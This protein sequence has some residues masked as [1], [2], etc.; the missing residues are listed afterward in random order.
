MPTYTLSQINI[1]ED[2]IP[3]YSAKSIKYA[4]KVTLDGK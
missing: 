4:I 1:Y 3:F 2:N